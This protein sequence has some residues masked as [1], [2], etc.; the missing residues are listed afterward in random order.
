MAQCGIERDWRAAGFQSYDCLMLTDATLNTVKEMPAK[1]AFFKSS[2]IRD[3]NEIS[4]HT[5][6]SCNYGIL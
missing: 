6:N 1:H 3:V 2:V 5:E 4:D